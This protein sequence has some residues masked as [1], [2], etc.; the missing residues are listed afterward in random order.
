M[1]D[2]YSEC[3]KSKPAQIDNSSISEQVD[4]V[5]DDEDQITIHPKQWSV[6]NFQRKQM[7]L[8]PFNDPHI[9]QIEC[10]LSRVNNSNL[11]LP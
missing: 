2:C 3:Q 4:H 1:H 7:E 5:S 11:Y 9:R 10:E 6:L 8:D